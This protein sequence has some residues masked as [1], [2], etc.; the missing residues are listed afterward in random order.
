[1]A[2]FILN[3]PSKMKSKVFEKVDYEFISL[4]AYSYK[5]KKHL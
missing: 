2:Y 4:P 5:N 1:M 3:K